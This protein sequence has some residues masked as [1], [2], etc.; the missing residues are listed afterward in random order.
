MAVAVHPRTVQSSLSVPATQNTAPIID[1]RCLYT[2][3][4]R[5]KQK[6]WQDGVLRFHTFN[7]R[8]MVYD[9]PRNF[10]GDTHWRDSDAIQDGDEFELDRGVLIQVGEQVGSVEQDLS[11]LLEKRQKAPDVPV[12]INLPSVNEQSSTANAPSSGP[13]QPLRPKSLN[14]V[15]GTPRGSI[16]RAAIPKQSPFEQRSRTEKPLWQQERPAKRQ[17]VQND[18]EKAGKQFSGSLSDKTKS[19]PPSEDFHNVDSLRESLAKGNRQ[20]VGKRPPVAPLI[21]KPSAATD[22]NV[23]TSLNSRF[24]HLQAAPSHL[25]NEKAGERPGN[26]EPIY[27]PSSHSDSNQQTPQRKR[28]SR[29]TREQSV[30]KSLQKDEQE[31]AEVVM[32]PIQVW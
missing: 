27:I 13:S 25:R 29:N 15:L 20:P 9:V 32:R 3:D 18:S 6:R 11:A 22:N 31:S 28:T 19:A 10:I 7:R 17:R 2:H 14:A 4:L 26:V 21:P 23:S 24:Y 5:R 12:K 1:Y 16:G 30:T 8:V